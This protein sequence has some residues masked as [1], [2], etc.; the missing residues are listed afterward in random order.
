MIGNHSAVKR[1]KWVYESLVNDRSCYKQKFYGIKSHQ[2][3]QMTPSLFYCTQQCLFC[4]RAQ[5][6][7]LQVTWDE[8]KLPSLNTPEEIVDGSIKAQEKILTGYKGN[9]KTNWRK[10]TEALTPK[11]V[12]ISLTGEPT[13]YEPIGELIRTYHQKGFTTFLVSNGTL[14]ARLSKLSQ[15]PTQLYISVC[16]PNEQVYNRVC[17]PQM[18]NAWENLNETLGLLQ[19]FKCPTV[20]RMTLVKGHNMSLVDEYAK[21]VEKANPTYI[22]AKAYMHIGF[23]TLRLG[24]DNMPQ[25]FEVKMFADEL[26]KKTGYMIIDDSPDSRVFLLSKTQKRPQAACSK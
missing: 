25:H 24:F 4:W 13:L 21:L 18:H 12:A 20:T 10:Y 22:E 26:A 23:S 7:D 15:E 5:S 8:M 11:H 19:S 1:C 9:P 2:C 14:P 16:A 3:I 17:R 6:G